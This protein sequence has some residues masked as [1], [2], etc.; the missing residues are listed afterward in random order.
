MKLK[1]AKV[2][3]VWNVLMK[4]KDCWTIPPVWLRISLPPQAAI[5]ERISRD[6][7]RSAGLR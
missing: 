3:S 7:K 2:I 1:Q 6:A 4:N 5:C